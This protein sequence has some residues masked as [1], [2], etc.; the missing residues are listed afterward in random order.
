[1]K[2]DA[3]DI[4]EKYIH[5]PVTTEFAIMYL[6]TEGLYAEAVGA[7]DLFDDLQREYKVTIAGPTTILALLNAFFASSISFLSALSY[8]SN[9]R[10]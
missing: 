2:E 7:L 8:A 9:K 6:P 4:C 3:R 5:P 1:M 10:S